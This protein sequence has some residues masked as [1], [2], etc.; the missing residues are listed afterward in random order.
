M[1]AGLSRIEEW[2]VISSVALGWQGIVWMI[3]GRFE[4]TFLRAGFEWVHGWLGEGKLLF[5]FH[6]RRCCN[7]QIGPA[8]MLGRLDGSLEE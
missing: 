3:P 6:L 7:L 5:L 2:A 1:I 8:G 4:V